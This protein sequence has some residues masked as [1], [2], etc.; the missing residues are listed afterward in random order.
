[1]RLPPIHFSPILPSS[2]SRSLCKMQHRKKVAL[3]KITSGRNFR[4]LASAWAIDHVH[5]L[6][7][8]RQSACSKYARQVTRLRS[9]WR[10]PLLLATIWYHSYL[11]S[12]ALFKSPISARP[13]QL[14]TMPPYPSN[15]GAPSKHSHVRTELIKRPREAWVEFSRFQLGKSGYWRGGAASYRCL[16]CRSLKVSNLL[17]SV[18]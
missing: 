4:S 6:F 10:I 1:M 11:L 3:Y 18:A 16:N 5:T 2:T 9:Q 17:I 14:I 7:C 12:L 8:L 13:S 15:N